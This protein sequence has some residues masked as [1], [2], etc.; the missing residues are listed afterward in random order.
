MAR[1]PCKDYL[2]GT[3]GTPLCEKRYPPECLFYKSENGC[4][5]GDKCSYAHR[6][7]DEQPS[8]KSRKNGDKSAVAILKIHGKWVA[9]FKICS[10]RSP[11]RFC[12]RAETYWSQ[13]DVFDLLKPCYVTLTFVTKIHRLEWFAQVI[14][15]SATPMLQNLRIGPKKR[16]NGKSDVPAKQRGI[17]PKIS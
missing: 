16:R 4:K 11:H 7:V 15:I 17:W 8:K 13:S 1:L 6:Q 9:Y 5:L 10:R 12:G 2:K 14:L 3:C